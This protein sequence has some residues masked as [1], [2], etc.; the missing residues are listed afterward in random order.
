MLSIQKTLFNKV[1]HKNS[2]IENNY[3]KILNMNLQN[4]SLERAKKQIEWIEKIQAN[5][6][7][8]TEAKNSKGCSYIYSLLEEK[9]YQIYI[10]YCS[11]KNHEYTDE[12]F[13]IIA[14]KNITAK[15]RNFPIPFLENRINVV[16]IES[17]IGPIHF[18]GLYV[19]THNEFDKLKNKKKEIFQKSFMKSF[20]EY[21]TTYN[22]FSI[23]ISGDL[24]VLEPNHIPQVKHFKQWEYFYKYFIDMGMIDPFKEL[25]DEMDY[26]WMGHHYSLR[27]DHFL[28]SLNL[29]EHTNKCHYMHETR[30]KKISDHSAM[31]LEIYLS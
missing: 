28:I 24:N 17:N 2:H 9:G 10:S 15:K 16:Q 4:P 8:L 21:I 5:L 11:K 23:I 29:L 19:P 30:I 27:L 3:L 18:F 25:N 26:S 13:V 1:Q 31:L 22:P 7:I 6:I 14:V 20:N 12:Y